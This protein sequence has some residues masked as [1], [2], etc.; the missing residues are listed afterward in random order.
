[1]GQWK[2]RAQRTIELFIIEVGGKLAKQAPV[3]FSFSFIFSHFLASQTPPED[4]KSEDERLNSLFQEKALGKGTYGKTGAL[5]F[6][7]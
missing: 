6:S 4:D 7:M 2:S 1:M 5:M 3:F